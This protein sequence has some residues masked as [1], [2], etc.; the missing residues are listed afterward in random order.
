MK[1]NYLLLLF[2][3]LFIPFSTVGAKIGTGEIRIKTNLPVGKMFKVDLFVYGGVDAGG[4]DIDDYPEEGKNISFEG[5]E[6][7]LFL[8]G[9]KAYLTISSQEIVIRGD[10]NYLSAVND[11]IT[12][13]DVSKA[14]KLRELR[15]N[16][17]LLAQLDLSKASDL[18]LVWAGENAN[19]T[20]LTLPE[21]GKLTALRIGGTK[22]SSVDFSEHTQLSS[23]Y[24]DSMPNLENADFSMLSELSEL[25]V[26]GNGWQ[27]LDV[28]H[29][30][31]LEWLECSRNDLSALDVTNN[32][33]LS[34]FSC[35]GNQLKGENMDKLIASLHKSTDFPK[36]EFCVYNSLYDKE[37][38][39]LTEEQATEAGNRGWEPK[40]AK[41]NSMDFFSWQPYEGVVKGIGKTTVEGAD[42]GEWYDLSGRRIAKPAAKGIYIHNGRKVLVR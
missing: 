1:K 18:S 41:G 33:K 35:W 8:G 21:S 17:N 36:P 15:V 14:P 30:P 7:A 4:D 28:S 20:T 23:L 10:V 19:L 40:Q 3:G 39:V 9:Y 13:I 24:L 32:T 29:N 26:N 27:S 22:I 11:K 37:R 31:K 5:V 12:D 42:K 38:N 2:L 34:F 25:W 16:Q 6:Q